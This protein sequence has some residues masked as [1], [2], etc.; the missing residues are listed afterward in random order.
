[1]FFFISPRVTTVATSRSSLERQN[2]LFSALDKDD[3]RWAT[4]SSDVIELV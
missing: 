3:N 1:V 2:F 4:D